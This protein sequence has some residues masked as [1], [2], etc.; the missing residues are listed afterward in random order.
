MFDQLPQPLL[1]LHTFIVN[2]G[3]T[4]NILGL[5]LM[6][7]LSLMRGGDLPG[8]KYH[9]MFFWFLSLFCFI[10]MGVMIFIA[11]KYGGA[12]WPLVVAIDL[13]FVV[14]SMICLASGLLPS[15]MLIIPQGEDSVMETT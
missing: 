9:R 8:V 13:A 2:V 10:V 5:I 11:N 14:T 7:A 12:G 15:K 3:I 1:D 6:L 4:L